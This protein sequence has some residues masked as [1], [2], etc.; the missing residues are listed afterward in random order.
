M[1]A[2][3]ITIVL[4]I[5]ASITVLSAQDEAVDKQNVQSLVAVMRAEENLLSAMKKLKSSVDAAVLFDKEKGLAILSATSA[6]E[7]DVA[8]VEVAGQKTQLLHDANAYVEASAQCRQEILRAGC[9]NLPDEQ[10]IIAGMDKL[11]ACA[12]AVVDYTKALSAFVDARKSGQTG[13]AELENILAT[14][15]RFVDGCWQH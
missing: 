5:S 6:G 13:D 1:A 11:D 15:K 12:A 14:R 9:A 3:K 8:I 4:A 10:K 7:K 2:G